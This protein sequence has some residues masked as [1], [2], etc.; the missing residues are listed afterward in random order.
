MRLCV[1][2][3]EVHIQI[4]IHAVEVSLFIEHMV[5]AINM[6]FK[7]C[8]VDIA[9]EVRMIRMHYMPESPKTRNVRIPSGHQRTSGRHTDRVLCIVVFK[10]CSLPG[11]P[12]QI[13]GDRHGIAVCMERAGPH[14]IRKKE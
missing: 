10:K 14:L 9:Q 6:G 8:L 7:T 5:L 1:P 3:A 11:K 2:M 4:F 13:G 12:V